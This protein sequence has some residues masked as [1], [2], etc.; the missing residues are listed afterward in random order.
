MLITPGPITITN[1]AGNRQK[2]N[3]NVGIDNIT[4]S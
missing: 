3:S 1:N 4:I 2:I